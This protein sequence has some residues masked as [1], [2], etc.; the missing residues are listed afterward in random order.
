MFCVRYQVTL[1]VRVLYNVM[2]KPKKI[3]RNV[4]RVFVSTSVLVWN[5][6]TANLCASTMACCMASPA[7]AAAADMHEMKETSCTETPVGFE[8]SIKNDDACCC[9]PTKIVKDEAREL[10]R[11]VNSEKTEVSKIQ[12]QVFSGIEETFFEFQVP[13]KFAHDPTDTKYP[14]FSSHDRILYLQTFLI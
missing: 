14:E 9:S 13:F 8:L 6:G 4:I 12:T 2:K 5:V 1:V 7:E 10:T 11:N 3:A